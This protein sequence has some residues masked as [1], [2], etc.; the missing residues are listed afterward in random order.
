MQLNLQQ[1]E[2]LFEK[3][4]DLLSFY[5][6]SRIYNKNYTLYLANGEVLNFNFQQGSIPHLLGIDT[7]YLEGTGFYK[8]KD[9]Y[10]LLNELIDNPYRIYTLLKSCTVSTDQ[11]FSP[12]I[13]EKVNSFKD[14]IKVNIFETDIVCSFNKDRLYLSADYD[15]KSDYIIVK[16]FDDGGIGITELCKNGTKSTPMSFRIYKSFDE[17]RE[18]LSKA[19]KHQEISYAT[20][21]N[22]YNRFTDETRSFYI[23]PANKIDK[24]NTVVSYKKE[25]DCIPDITEDYRFILNKSVGSYGEKGK[26]NEIIDDIAESISEGKII[27]KYSE[28]RLEAIIKAYN[29]NLCKSGNT[30][31]IK[32]YSKQREELLAL[33]SKVKEIEAENKALKQEL[34]DTKDENKDL[35]EEL[36]DSKEKIKKI[37]EIINP[38]I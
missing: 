14:N 15:K 22:V 37:N 13:L 5:E 2:D 21:L 33:R 30:N 9:G 26:E 36:T 19:L 24:V 34:T 16:T 18:Y 20:N 7:F 29:D 38:S 3:I 11:L 6:R 32:S 17:A 10:E 25:F 12:Y 8:G 23:N 28:T 31:A 35:E 1:I 4:K 27:D